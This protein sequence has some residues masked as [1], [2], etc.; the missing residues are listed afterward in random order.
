M[1]KN[2]VKK[3]TGKI[4]IIGMNLVEMR[5][6]KNKTN[7]SIASLEILCEKFIKLD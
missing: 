4:E 6:H 3:L 2:S 7:R 5:K 1:L